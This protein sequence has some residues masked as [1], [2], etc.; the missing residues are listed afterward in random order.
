MK[1]LQGFLMRLNTINLTVI[2]LLTCSTQVYS[3]VPSIDTIA[4]QRTEAGETYV[5]QPS[6]AAGENVYWTKVFGP[7]DVSVHPITGKVTWILDNDAIEESYHL[8]VKAS[9]NEGAIEEAW[10]VTVGSGDVLYIGPNE[11]I[12]T[13]KE[14]MSAI[15]SGDTLVMRNGTWGHADQDNT[16][17]GNQKKTQTLPAGTPTA[18]TTL[19]AEDPGGVIIDGNDEEQLISLWG[20]EKHPDWPLSN[21]GSTTDT[22]YLA[23]KGLVLINSDAE[24]VR[25]NNSKYIKLIDLGIGPSSRDSGAYANVYVYRSQYVLIE[26]MYVWGHG[27]YKIQFKNSSEGIV[28]RS[29]V[30]IDDYIGGEPIG[31]YITYCSRNILFQNNILIDSDHSHYWGSHNE[32]INAFGVPA[33]NCY[34]YPEFNEFNKGLALNAHMGL[35]NTDARDNSNPSLW[36]DIVGWDLKPAR[37]SGGNG[38]VVPMLSGVGATITD[39]M[40]LGEVNSEGSYFMYSRELDSTVKN[41]LLF[42]VGWNGTDTVDQGALIRRGSGG[43]FYFSDNNLV[44]FVGELT[45]SSGSG[46]PIETNTMSIQP[47][48]RYLTMLPRDSALRSS[49]ENEGRIGAEL[50]TMSGQSGVFYGD[51]GYDSETDIPM[52]PFPNQQLAHEH[53][54]SFTHSGTDREGG[55]EGIQ[56]ARGFA[57]ANQTVTNYVWSYL[58]SPT[59]PFNVS[60]VQGDKRLKLMW[61]QSAPIYQDVISG[62]NVYQIEDGES[63]L[64]ASIAS[65]IHEYTLPDLVNGEA[66]QLAVTSVREGGDESDY[67]YAVTGNPT[68]LS[69]PLPP[70]LT[71]E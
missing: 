55:T 33:T 58:G 51:P 13:L 60:V 31:G 65:N 39:R 11:L 49:G 28:R 34:D 50:L 4:D 52:W 26:G 6:L 25:V 56:G 47:E 17:P 45:D 69:A 37:H 66:V 41:S 40:T 67:A 12:T 14:G 27:R 64:L 38:A 35:M 63:S 21:N 24:A 48:L 15:E 30:R 62:Y 43:S 3:A 23:I 42:R 1:I 18:F 36:Q 61:S 20:S 7:D 54:A 22:D 5:Y 59:P 10:I 68:V 29:I 2:F 57:V 9:N 16:I 44:D 71:I 8:G 32:I 46:G 70:T 53:F 19:M